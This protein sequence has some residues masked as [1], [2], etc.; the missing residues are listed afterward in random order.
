MANVLLFLSGIFLGTVF[1]F[2][3]G[4]CF[5]RA[6]ISDLES[7]SYYTDQSLKDIDKSIEALTGILSEKQNKWF[8]HDSSQ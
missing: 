5:K 2:L 7:G 1:G 4:A 6:K 3:F 8:L